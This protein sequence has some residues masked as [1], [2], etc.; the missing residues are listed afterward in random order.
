MKNRHLN[1][2]N[3]YSQI[4]LTCKRFSNRFAI[5]EKLD[6]GHTSNVFKIKDLKSEKLFALKAYNHRNIQSKKLNQVKKQFLKEQDT[7]NEIRRSIDSKS[8]K[9]VVKIVDGF[10]EKSELFLVMELMH[11]NL[12]HD[13]VNI[14][15]IREILLQMGRVLKSMHSKGFVHLDIRPG[16]VIR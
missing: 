6:E 2:E 9:H 3:K 14:S 4:F 16:G 13:L 11:G 15:D 10:A 1:S 8:E 12:H 5:L 7:L